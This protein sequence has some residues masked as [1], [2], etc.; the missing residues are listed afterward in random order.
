MFNRYETTDNGRIILT[1]FDGLPNGRRTYGGNAGMKAS[2]VWQDAHWMVKFPESTAAMKGNVR[3]YTTSPV[4]EWLASHIYAAAGIPVHDTVLGLMR[5][6]VVVACRDF[7]EPNKRLN[8][9]H[10]IK[11]MASFLEPPLPDGSDSTGSSMYLND[12]LASF[13][14]NSYLIDVPGVEER[15]WD[16]FVADTLTGNT[17]RNNTNWGLLMSED[18]SELAPVYDNGNSFFNKRTIDAIKGDLGD[19]NRM[20][21]S[22]ISNLVFNYLDDAGRKIH[23][24]K[25]M[26]ESQDPGCHAAINRFINAFNPISAEIL[27]DAL[28]S[29]AMGSIVM[30]P[31]VARFLKEIIYIRYNALLGLVGPDSGAGPRVMERTIARA[32]EGQKPNYLEDLA[33]ARKVIEDGLEEPPHLPVRHDDGSVR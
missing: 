12:I 31:T 30:D 1:D 7:E 19:Q 14:L 27:I 33:I 4:S 13:R 18:T 16:M 2:I 28:P 11:N 24:F 6:K 23:P 10:D 8:D 26:A 25:Y 21:A 15:F 20:R 22:A 17:D 32:N 3:S 29:M 9:Y 5:G